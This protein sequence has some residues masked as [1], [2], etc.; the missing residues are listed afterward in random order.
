MVHFV[1]RSEGV[2]LLLNKVV[3]YGKAVVFV[4]GNWCILLNQ[5]VLYDKALCVCSMKQAMHN[6]LLLCTKSEFK[7]CDLC[8]S[9]WRNE[10]GLM[11]KHII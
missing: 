3:L 8:K 6:N 9:N 4:L 10:C 2:F 11:L 5:V 7:I 1:M